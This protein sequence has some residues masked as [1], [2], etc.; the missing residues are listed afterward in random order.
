MDRNVCGHPQWTAVRLRPSTTRGWTNGSTWHLCHTDLA[1]VEVD[2]KIEAAMAQTRTQ[3]KIRDKISAVRAVVGN[4]SNNEIVLVLQQF[5]NNVDKTVQAF[6]DGSAAEVLKEWSTPMK[7]KTILRKKN[8]KIAE[9]KKDDNHG[10]VEIASLSL[11]LQFSPELEGELAQP[12]SPLINGS[13]SD[14]TSDLSETLGELHLESTTL[15]KDESKAPKAIVEDERRSEMALSGL[16]TRPPSGTYPAR[17]HDSSSKAGRGFFATQHSS[18]VTDLPDVPFSPSLHNKKISKGAIS[19]GVSIDKSVKDL[20]RCAA[21]LS[22]Y[23]RLIKDEID[24][25]IKRI[26]TTFADVQQSLMDREVNLMTE[27]DK[28]KEE[29]VR[30]LE[31]RQATALVLKKQADQASRMDEHQLSELRGHIKHFVSERK[32]DEELSKM[33]R[34]VCDVECLKQA[35]EEF[36][37]VTHPKNFYSSK[38]NYDTLI[39]LSSHKVAAPPSRARGHCEMTP[40]PEADQRQA[41]R[42][43]QPVPTQG[44]Q[45]KTASV[46]SA[47]EHNA[48]PVTKGYPFQGTQRVRRFGAGYR[49]RARGQQDFGRGGIGTSPAGGENYKSATHQR[50][51]MHGG[52]RRNQMRDMPKAQVQGKLPPEPNHNDHEEN[53]ESTMVKTSLNPKTANRETPPNARPQRNPRPRQNG[54]RAQASRGYNGLQDHVPNGSAYQA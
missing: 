39:S 15:Q 36:G 22:R 17:G 49:P 51:D 10:A 19:T 20:Q 42:S 27:M 12:S 13:A 48:H 2:S 18:I 34:F 32:Y 16:P 44:Q 45:A 7:K 31:E 50:R 33:V 3:E 8:K 25:S 43:G 21:S 54:P 47:E 46:N 1:G 29:T 28:V 24:G 5:D 4:K 35:L 30:L 26:K 9:Q 40:R 53:R 41:E 14:E 38:P 52:Y 6:M 37:E 23:R 11:D